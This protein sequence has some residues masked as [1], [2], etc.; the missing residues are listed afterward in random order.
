MKF[1]SIG[2]LLASLS[3]ATAANDHQ[4]TRMRRT[5]E[6]EAESSEPEQ[7]S[8]SGAGAAK[9]KVDCD[10]SD[11]TVQFAR[12]TALR[13]LASNLLFILPL[14]GVDK[15]TLATKPVTYANGDDCD[16]DDKEHVDNWGNCAIASDDY[17]FLQQTLTYLPDATGPTDGHA[18]V[19]A[20]NKHF[21][22]TCPN[23]LL[24][25][26]MLQQKLLGSD[27]SMILV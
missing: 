25:L 2:L 14:Q 18:T 22:F 17:A 26:V 8:S 4:A 6:V 24:E 9:K 16:P 1:A 7:S 23:E 27:P 3:A 21:E 13:S 19:A 10:L 12:L 11:P 5:V 15:T 20:L